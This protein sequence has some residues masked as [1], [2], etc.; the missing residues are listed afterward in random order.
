[1]KINNNTFE[2]YLSFCMIISFI[3]ILVFGFF[4]NSYTLTL[5]AYKVMAEPNGEAEMTRKIR[6]VIIGLV[7]SILALFISTFLFVNSVGITNYWNN[8]QNRD[9]ISP[10]K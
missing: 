10:A 5:A 2:S 4:L 1:M 3:L 8:M 9:S 6:N 7:V